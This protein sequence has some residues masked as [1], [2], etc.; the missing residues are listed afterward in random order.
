MF[1]FINKH[2]HHGPIIVVIEC[3]NAQS[4]KSGLRALDDFP[5]VSIPSMLVI[6]LGW[7]QVVAK[8]GMQ[9]C[10]ATSQWLN[11]RISLSRYAHGIL[12]LIGSY[13]HQTSS[14][15]QEHFVIRN[16][17]HI[18]LVPG[19]PFAL[20]FFHQPSRSLE[21]EL[22]SSQRLS[23]RN[24]PDPHLGGFDSLISPI[25]SSCSSLFS[26][27][28]SAPSPSEHSLSELSPNISSSIESTSTSSPSKSCNIR[29]YVMHI[30]RSPIITSADFGNRNL[31]QFKSR[32]STPNIGPGNLINAL[33]L[34]LFWLFHFNR[35]SFSTVGSRHPRTP[36]GH[37]HLYHLHRL[38]L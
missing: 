27:S 2:E 4:I 31:V 36:H 25:I 35:P 28:E 30:N 16:S 5:C 17:L 24:G 21:K 22:C 13:I 18:S 7:Q 29:E 10:A 32:R 14:N 15:F 8:I 23:K 11:E 1:W 33:N 3:P 37:P 12:N 6:V 19:K 9:R 38:H 26:V 20:A 34:R